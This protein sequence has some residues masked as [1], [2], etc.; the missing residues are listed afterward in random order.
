MIAIY[1][2][3]LKHHMGRCCCPQ[4]KNLFIANALHDDYFVACLH[5]YPGAQVVYHA[6]YNVQGAVDVPA[7]GV[8]A[9]AQ[10][11]AE[12]D[13]AVYQPQHGNVSDVS[14][15]ITRVPSR[16]CFKS[17]A[18]HVQLFGGEKCFNTLTKL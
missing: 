12:D 18:N 16:Y 13:E 1:C 10:V 9:A 2:S 6:G 15:R 7:A 17:K 3:L 8:G 4:E 14:R 11:Q 5:A